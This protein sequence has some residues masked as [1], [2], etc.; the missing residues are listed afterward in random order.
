M[1]ISKT[2]LLGFKAQRTTDEHVWFNGPIAA[3][4]SSDVQS[5]YYHQRPWRCLWSGLLPEALCE[6]DM[7]S[8]ACPL[9]LM[10]GGLNN[11]EVTRAGEL[12]MPLTSCST[13]K[14]RPTPE[15]STVKLTLVAKGPIS[16]LE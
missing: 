3:G 2:M 6:G 7:S 10:A 9:L 12:A 15:G 11:F 4:F 13:L 5:P 14:S 1:G 8:S 16:R